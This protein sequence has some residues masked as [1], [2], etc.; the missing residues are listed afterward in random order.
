VQGT[1]SSAPH[2]YVGSLDEGMFVSD[3]PVLDALRE[4]NTRFMAGDV[5]S[6]GPVTGTAGGIPAHGPLAVVVA[7]SDARVPV[8]HVFHQAPGALFVVRVAG[9]VLEPAGLASVRLAVA[10]LG[11]RVVVVLGHEACGACA[12]PGRSIRLTRRAYSAKD[13]FGRDEQGV[14]RGRCHTWQ[15][16]RNGEGTEGVPGARQR[17]RPRGSGRRRCRVLAKNARSRMVELGE[18]Q[19]G[20]TPLVAS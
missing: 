15:R 9:Q 14:D 4:G 7:C 8:E 1:W 12:G 16:C 13:R 6:V 20:A 5:L 2:R 18:E 10:Q 17:D 3:H 11:T 19:M